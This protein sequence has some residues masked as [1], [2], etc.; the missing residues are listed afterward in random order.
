MLGIL[1]A[2]AAI[3]ALL[4]FTIVHPAAAVLTLFIWG[5]AAFAT[6]PGLQMRVVDQARESPTLASTLNI[7]AFN[8]GNALGAWLGGRLIDAGLPLHIV[9]LGAAAMALAALAIAGIGTALERRD[10]RA[11]Q[12]TSP[13]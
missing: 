9:P 8:L 11:V 7:A 2:L 1:L 6:V 13:S 3:E 5:V 4:S 10:L 12:P